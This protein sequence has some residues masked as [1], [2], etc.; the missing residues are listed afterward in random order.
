MHTRIHITNS[1]LLNN[2]SSQS[3]FNSNIFQP[4]LHIEHFSLNWLFTLD[5]KFIHNPTTEDAPKGHRFCRFMVT[6]VCKIQIQHRR[7]QS[8]IVLAGKKNVQINGTLYCPQTKALLNCLVRR[9]YLGCDTSPQIAKWGKVLQQ[10]HLYRLGKNQ[11]PSYHHG[12][13]LE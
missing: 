3:V 9:G 8:R 4:C 10:S 7:G 2:I 6:R 1:S 12:G 5:Y 13:H 11:I